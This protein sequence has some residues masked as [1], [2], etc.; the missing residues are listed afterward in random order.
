MWGLKVGKLAL[1]YSCH[2]DSPAS[3][4]KPVWGYLLCCPKWIS[5]I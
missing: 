3:R 5:N 2:P 4:N 1:R